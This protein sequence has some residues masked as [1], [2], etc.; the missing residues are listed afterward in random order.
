MKTIEELRAHYKA[1]R[2][3]LN[4]GPPKKDP[5]PAPIVKK[6]RK[7]KPKPEPVVEEKPRLTPLTPAQ[8][9]IREVAIKHGVTTADMRGI[10]RKVKFVRARQ[11]AVYEVKKRLNLSLPLIGRVM[12][13]KD[14]TTVLH[15]IRKHAQMNN[16][17]H[18]GALK[19]D[20]AQS[21]LYIP[22]INE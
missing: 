12:G 7:K 22:Q 21:Y 16:L 8:I 10:S 13:N 18:L 6:K 14:H 20:R 11:E 3:I 4:A 15:G 5:P 2:N 1:V 17:P 9:I 19:G